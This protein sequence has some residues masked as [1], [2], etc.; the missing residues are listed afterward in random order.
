MECEAGEASVLQT[1]HEIAHRK[2]TRNTD[3]AN[4]Q[5]DEA[6]RTPRLG[7]APEVLN[8]IEIR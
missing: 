5:I 1:P 6:T 8:G 4:H 3:A 2:R 7:D